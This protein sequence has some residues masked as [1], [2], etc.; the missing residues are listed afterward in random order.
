MGR[1]KWAR[2]GVGFKP[3]MVALHANHRLPRTCLTEDLICRPLCHLQ[4]DEWGP[5]GGCRLEADEAPQDWQ[6][7]GEA[8]HLLRRVSALA[9]LAEC[10]PAMLF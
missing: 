4:Q 10:L 5:P 9:W 8:I 1:L 7:A 6:G 2:W 3:K